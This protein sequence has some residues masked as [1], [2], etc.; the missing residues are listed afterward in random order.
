[1]RLAALAVAALALA[2]PLAHAQPDP[3][4]VLHVAFLI[5]ETGFDP[6]ASSDL[7]SNYVNRVIF[8][9]LFRYDYL[10][11]PHKDRKSVV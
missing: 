6:Q 7:Y 11:R 2:A 5:A 9:P 1:M 10:A 3:S 8:D 4:K